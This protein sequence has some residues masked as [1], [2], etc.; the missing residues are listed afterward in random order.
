[1]RDIFRPSH[2]PAQVI[3]DA[4]QKVAFDRSDVSCEEW[5]ARERK[6]VWE[7]ARDYAQMHSLLVPT[8]EQVEAAER[9]A[10]GHVDYGAKW[11]WGVAAAME[12][13]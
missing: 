8:I 10:T 7:A 12:G 13:R 4:F 9:N 3:Y 5:I 11:A 2:G 6:A 1:M